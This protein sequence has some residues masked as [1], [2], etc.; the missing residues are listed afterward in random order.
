MWSTAFITLVYK[1]FFTRTGQN[2]EQSQDTFQNCSR[3]T[4]CRKGDFSEYPNN[5]A[6]A[7]CAGKGQRPVKNIALAAE[8]CEDVW[9]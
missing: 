8:I 7:Y 9:W 3:P 2:R 4:V 1:K 5:K 6:A